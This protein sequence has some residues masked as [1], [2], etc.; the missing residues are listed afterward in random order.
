MIMFGKLLIQMGKCDEALKY[1][2]NLLNDPYGED[3]ARIYNEIGV[4]Y[5][6]EYER[7]QALGNFQRAYGIMMTIL[8]HIVSKILLDR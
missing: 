4:A 5:I 7:D 2:K 3:I 6:L 1:F 8:N